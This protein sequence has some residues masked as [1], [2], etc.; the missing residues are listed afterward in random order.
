[1]LKA[2]GARWL[3]CNVRVMNYGKTAKEFLIAA[4]LCWGLLALVVIIGHFLD[5]DPTQA[6]QGILPS[7]CLLLLAMGGMTF[8][9]ALIMAVSGL[10]NRGLRGNRNRVD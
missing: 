1:M 5:P 2:L 8:A 4:V 7:I 10:I 3:R 9:M 6:D